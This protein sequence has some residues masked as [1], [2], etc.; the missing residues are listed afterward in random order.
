M[1]SLNIFVSCTLG[2][3]V[4]SFYKLT[5]H[6]LST[7]TPDVLSRTHK[8]YANQW[9][10]ISDSIIR[11]T[12][13]IVQFSPY[14]SVVF[15]SYI[16]YRRQNGL[17]IDFKT[18]F[19]YLATALTIYSTS[20]LVRGYGRMKNQ[21]YLS[22]LEILEKSK[23]NFSISNKRILNHFD[24]EYYAHP[25]DYSWHDNAGDRKAPV[26]YK[27]MFP[28][29]NSKYIVKSMPD[30]IFK[31]LSGFIGKVAM[32]TVGKR[33]VYPGTL[34]ALQALMNPAITAGREKLILEHNGVRYKLLSYSGDHI[35]SLFIDNRDSTLNGDYLVVGCEGN[36]GYY[37]VGT[38][39]TP[40]E[41]GYSVLGWNHPGFGG[42]TGFPYPEN[43]VAAVDT[44]IN[45]AVEKLNFPLSRIIV[46]G[47]SIGG[48][49]ASWAGM[50][51]PGL[52]GLV[53]D[54]SF[55]HII[56]ISKKVVPS[57]ISPIAQIAIE[58]HFDL[59]NSFHLEKFKGPIII[60]RRTQ[61][62]VISLNPYEPTR[63]NRG[64]D[65]LID[66]LEQ[67]YPSLMDS[68]GKDLVREYLD[69]N[70]RHQEIVLRRYAADTDACIGLLSIA[71]D[72]LDNTSRDRLV[73]YLAS[74]YLLEYDS[75]HCAP[76]PPRYFLNIHARLKKLIE[77]VI[78]QVETL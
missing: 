35:D 3:K 26:T 66:L 9:E 71:P 59:N 55:D 19:K 8:Y 67:R 46:Y 7:R 6:T 48:F 50:R 60:I 40:L 76:L 10:S 77:I 20:F 33:L 12:R 28:N 14:L 43:E 21:E 62:E 34:A 54:A 45:F 38:I 24:F 58:D 69:G 56:P 41:A 52:C 37:E 18:T 2:P 65:L 73:L 61:D 39:L 49:T 17:D 13:I 1:S 29:S 64:N 63:T 57:F 23:K 31:W 44:V 51:F 11:L 15:F 47:W 30:S 22:F 75:V 70:S 36:G 53:I 74:R 78:H 27:K 16:L 68:R 25:T 5:G 4:Y 32:R 42:S 72:R